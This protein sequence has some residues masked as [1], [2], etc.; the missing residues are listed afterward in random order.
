MIP[1]SSKSQ[2]FKS[3]KEHASASNFGSP[4]SVDHALQLINAA[5]VLPVI[6]ASNPAQAYQTIQEIAQ[7]GLGIAELT[8]TT[9]AWVDLVSRTRRDFPDLLVGVGTLFTAND[10]LRALKAGAHFLVSPC[11]APDVAA[12]AAAHNVLF[13]EGGLTPAELAS[14]STQGVAKLFPA[15]LGGPKYL[16][17]LRSILPDAKIIPTGGIAIDDVPDWLA[18]GAFAVGIGSELAS[19]HELKINLQRL[20]AFGESL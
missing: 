1:G 5:Q 17:S 11:P 7:C 8:A 4:A 13:I 9:P 2:T 20:L 19:G 10:A 14:A 16:R 18:A 12:V 15:H 3:T 6:R